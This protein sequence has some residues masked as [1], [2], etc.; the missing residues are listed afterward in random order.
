MTLGYAIGLI[1]SFLSGH[2]EVNV[3]DTGG[4]HGFESATPV[5]GEYL[6]WDESLG[7]HIYSNPGGADQDV[8][9]SAIPTF[10]DVILS[11]LTENK[12]V[13]TNADKKVVTS[14]VSSTELGYLSGATSNLQS[15]INGITVTQSI[16]GNLNL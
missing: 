10:R 13:M 8:G 14:S 11:D 9:T 4:V 2:S 5:N 15:Q 12:A 7:K 3:T 1:Q 6:K 16:W